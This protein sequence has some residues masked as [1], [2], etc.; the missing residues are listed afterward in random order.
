MTTKKPHTRAL[1]VPFTTTLPPEVRARRP[2]VQRRGVFD[3]TAP[4]PTPFPPRGYSAA[5]RDADVLLARVRR[6]AEVIKTCDCAATYTRASW[7]GL[8][9]VGHMVVEGRPFLELR[10]CPCGSTIAIQVQP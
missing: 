8:P 5:I 7:R 2:G 9:F 4:I 6:R 10:I 3:M 1:G